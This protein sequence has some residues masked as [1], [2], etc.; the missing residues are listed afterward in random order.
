MQRI[1][2]QKYNTYYEDRTVSLKK[3]TD[4]EEMPFT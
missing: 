3:L 2:E 4:F 1:R